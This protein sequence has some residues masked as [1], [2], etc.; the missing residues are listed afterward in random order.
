MDRSELAY[1]C[2][3][4]AGLERAAMAGHLGILAIR[5]DHQDRSHRLPVSPQPRRACQPRCIVSGPA[6]GTPAARAV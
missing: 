5:D 6:G 2:G 1:R 4:S 3:G